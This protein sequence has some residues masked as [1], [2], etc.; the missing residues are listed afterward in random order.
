[1]TDTRLILL[2][3]LPATGKS[4]IS[5]FLRVQLER[6]GKKAKWIHEVA[7]PHPVLLYPEDGLRSWNPPLDEYEASVLEKWARFSE[8]AAQEKDTVY[9]LDSSFFQA[10]I[11]FFLWNNAPYERLEKF[12]HKLYDAVERLRPALIY[13]YREN[14][15]DSIA[16]LEKDRG[17]QGL[18]SIWERD[19]A[20]P[21]YRDKPAGAEGFKQFLRDYAGFAGLLFDSLDCIKLPV[22]ISGADWPRHRNEMLV[23]LALE[24][25][26][27][28]AFY[29]PNGTY[30][31]EALGYKIIVEGLTMTDPE[32]NGRALTPKSDS[33]FYVECLPVI[34]RFEKPGRLV[35]SGMQIIAR[36]TATGMIYQYEA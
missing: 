31:N 10:Q 29:P 20:R 30:K 13:L 34:L 22:E 7:S 11:F 35:M 28:P 18:E 23:F 19:K 25:M 33:E 8:A 4:T 26:A 14:T 16:Y 3:G 9:V 24:N 2:E 1:M 36:W 17:I 6:N 32:G 5:G 27:S 21:Y 12:I 15:E